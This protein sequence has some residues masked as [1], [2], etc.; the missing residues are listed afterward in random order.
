[1]GKRGVGPGHPCFVVAEIGSNHNLSLDMARELIQASAEAGADAVK[2]QS[3]RLEEQYVPTRESA[4]FIAFFR[5]TELPEDWY[6]ALA[7]AAGRH[8][9]V[10]FSA[11]TYLRSVDL[12]EEV[13]VPLFKIASPQAATYPVLVERVARTGKPMIVSTGMVT[14]AGLDGLVRTIQAAGNDAVAILHCVS[15]YPTAPAEANLRTMLTYRAMFGCPVGFSDHTEGAHVAL[16]AVALGASVL[17][18]HIT[19]DR[20]LPG[21]DH[22][23]ATEPREFGAM[24][25]SLRDVEASLGDGVR[26]DLDPELQQFVDRIDMRLVA[27]RDIAAGTALSA[28]VF[29]HRRT[30]EGIRV[31]DLARLQGAVAARPIRAGEPVHWDDVR[32]KGDAPSP[33]A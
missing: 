23:F 20:T 18:K 9:V 12:L 15:R 33:G 25:R 32:L 5:G 30:R 10:F 8:G 29:V 21:P 1:M 6:P 26:G 16:A 11:P 17:E 4:D 19:L 7:D 24:V 13:G 28:S 27:A 3:Q 2:F 14:Y 31:A 22:V